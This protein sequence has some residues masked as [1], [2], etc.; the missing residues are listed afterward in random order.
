MN[1]HCFVNDIKIVTSKAPPAIGPYSQGIING[2][3]IFTAGQIYMGLDGKLIEGTV[4]EKV[5]QVMKNL[6]EV[7][8]SGGTTFA[9]V[10]KAKVYITDFSIFEQFNK[11]YSS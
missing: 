5:R 4:E 10:V 2:N 6:E 1:S 9:D 11:V 8:K 7:L 3:L